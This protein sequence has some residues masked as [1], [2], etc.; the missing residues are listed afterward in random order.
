MA[1]TP[2]T[3]RFVHRGF[4]SFGAVEPT[5][6]V[7]FTTPSGA[8]FEAQSGSK[9]DW[10]RVENTRGSGFFSMTPTTSGQG[11]GKEA[12]ENKK[13]TNSV[14]TQS[15]DKSKASITGIGNADNTML[16]LDSGG[17]RSATFN[18]ASG[19][20]AWSIT[21]TDAGGGTVTLRAGNTELVVNG[22][23]GQVEVTKQVIQ[24][25]PDHKAELQKYHQD[26]QKSLREALKPYS[27][28][29]EN[30]GGDGQTSDSNGSS[31]SCTDC[32]GTGVSNS[33]PSGVHP[34]GI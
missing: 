24:E 6:G 8:G 10:V 19:T 2:G 33:A 22:A 9:H 4:E 3:P 25:K 1:A 13:G 7:S 32:G 23:K 20:G 31:S 27:D 18:V 30:C 11:N 12:I 28:K 26:I 17:G 14:M 21:A 29:C 16:T 5:Q 34:S 15:G